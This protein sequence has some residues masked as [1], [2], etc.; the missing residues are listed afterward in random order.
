MTD[1][2]LLCEFLSLGEDC[3]FSFIQRRAGAEPL[4]MLRFTGTTLDKVIIGF[5]DGF[6]A[7]GDPEETY[8]K[9]APN[10]EVFCMNRRLGF[11]AH[12]FQDPDKIDLVQFQARQCQRLRLLRRKFF[13]DIKEG[14]KILVY[15]R[16]EPVAH[17]QVARLH[18]LIRG[19]GPANLLWVVRQ[20]E[21][22]P[23]GSVERIGEGFLKG[24]IDDFTPFGRAAFG[25]FDVWVEICR[26]ARKLKL[27]GEPAASVRDNGAER[28]TG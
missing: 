15:K 1:S 22:H 8:I 24:Y 21:G 6:E 4:E 26:G 19:L 17:D 12:T 28:V 16:R 9:V 25:S 5:K 20:E 23:P 7:V 11:G 10:R 13:E 2:E 18:R 27:A 3:E 14:Q